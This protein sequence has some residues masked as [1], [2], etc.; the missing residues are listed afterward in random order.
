MININNLN[1]IKGR[2]KYNSGRTRN[3]NSIRNKHP[4]V[5]QIRH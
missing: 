2:D 3:S 5:E 1:K 4:I